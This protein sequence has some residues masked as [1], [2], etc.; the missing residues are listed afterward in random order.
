MNHTRTL[1][2]GF[3]NDNLVIKCFRCLNRI[4]KPKVVVISESKNLS[5][6]DLATLFEK[7]L[8]YEIELKRLV[9]DQEGD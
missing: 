1:S 9:N 8:E 3:Q 2:K 6:M 4:W 5:S 7:L